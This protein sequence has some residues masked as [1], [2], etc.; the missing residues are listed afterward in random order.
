MQTKKLIPT[1]D[2][3]SI[4]QLI[5][6][7]RNRVYSNANAELVLL[8]LNVG[9]IVSEKVKNGIWGEGTV[10]E[11]AEF[12]KKKQPTLTAFN[13]RGL[14]RMK[15]FYDTYNIDS[16]C[17]KLWHE[18]HGE[19]V[20]PTATLLDSAE[21]QYESFLHTV[22]SQITWSNHL[23]ML[24]G[25][26]SAEQK[27]FYLMFNIQ[28]RWNKLE[29]RRQLQSAFFERTMLAN[30]MVSPKATPL[31]KD[32]FK[33]PYIFEFLDLPQNHSEK[34]LEKALIQNLQKFILEIGKGFTYLGNQYRLQVGNKDYYT[35]LL[36]FHRD[37]RCLVLFELKIEEFQPE[38]LGKI[39]FYLE[40]L[41]REV[42]RPH[43]NPSI[44]ILLCTSKDM[45][46]VEFA[47]ARC[48]SPTLIA[49]YETKL[50]DKKTLADKLH[51]LVALFNRKKR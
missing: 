10:E 3:E 23:E 22:L 39:N 35:D 47:T 51:Q 21:N 31:P 8:Y 17:F 16:S 38:F 14:Y 15:Q 48:D 12:I 26:K 25:A 5:E 2:F 27:V 36:F 49:E 43:E 37:L 6:A 29:L 11:L 34:D 18:L 42:K 45:E 13:R 41:D 1:T 7:S 44:G 24:S 30:Q 19:K 28:E 40:A 32:F 9:Q 33:E 50:I 4:L 20:S 46:V